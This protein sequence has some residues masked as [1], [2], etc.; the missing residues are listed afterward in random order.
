M[1][2]QSLILFSLKISIVLSVFA[3]GL[4][5]TLADALYL[6]HR[7]RHLARAF[8]SLNVL[9]PLFALLLV[10]TFNLHPA[11]KIALV[12]LSVS[13]VPPVFPKKVS[14]ARDKD[15][16]AVGL[17]VAASVLA[18]AVIPITMEVLERTRGIT[19]SMPARAVAILVFATVFAPLLTGIFLRA[20][21]PS[22]A[23]RT[24]KPLGTLAAVLLVLCFIPV[25]FSSARAVVSL[26]GDGTLLSMAGFVVAGSIIGYLLG[27]PEPENRQVLSLATAS[28]HPGVAIA[29]AHAN[30]PQQKLV[31]PAVLLYLIVSGILAALSSRRRAR[32]ELVAAP[33]GKKA[34][35]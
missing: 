8:L 17:L 10:F 3:I 4:R 25:L 5:A 9:M 14:K 2:L 32:A 31:A 11:V 13:P 30:F 6:F 26:I 7:P 1:D 24:A 21:A 29:I 22:F 16:Y 33:T 19:L 18:I 28:R 35:A 34:A 12:A 20:V 27:G 23:E 15:D